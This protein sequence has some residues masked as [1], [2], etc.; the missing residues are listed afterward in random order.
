VI[1][2]L[3]MVIMFLVPSVF[4]LVFML[5]LSLPA[6]LASWFFAGIFKKFE[7]KEPEDELELAEK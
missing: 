5:G 7:P 6:Y 4:P 1:Y 2:A 3:P